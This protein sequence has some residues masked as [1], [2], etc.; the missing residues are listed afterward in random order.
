MYLLYSYFTFSTNLYIAYS[1]IE[2][3]NYE[4]TENNI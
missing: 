2:F 1:T 3:N 4:S